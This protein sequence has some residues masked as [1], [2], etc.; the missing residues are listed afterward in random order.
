MVSRELENWS[1]VWE[2]RIHLE[3]PSVWSEQQSVCDR[4]LGKAF[5]NS[6]IWAERTAVQKIWA[7]CHELDGTAGMV[8]LRKP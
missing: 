5:H 1:L 2:K 7:L 4:W 3:C 8:A 6:D